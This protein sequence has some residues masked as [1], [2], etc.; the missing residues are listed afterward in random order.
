M[1]TPHTATLLGTAVLA[2]GGAAPRYAR[3]ALAMVAG[4][5]LI[6][7]SARLQVPMWPV[8]M[9]M[10]ALAVLAVGLAFGARLGA[11]TVAL[12]LAEGA[13][14]LPVFAGGAGSAYMAGPTGGFLL[15]FVAAAATAGWC[16]DRGWTQN[17][18]GTCAAALAGTIL[19]HLLGFVWLTWLAG[20]QTALTAGILPFVPGDLVKVAILALAFPAV[21]RL[22]GRD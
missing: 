2:N 17:A 8:P 20:A 7:I 19:I 12:Y 15:G 10:Q 22:F 5:L 1:T 14:G 3:S 18:A 21:W 6:A 13:V 9:T 11:A 4:T 16:A